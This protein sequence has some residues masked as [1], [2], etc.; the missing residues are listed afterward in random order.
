MSRV[1]VSCFSI[2]VDGY[3]AGP[4]QT[5]EEPLGKGGED[6]HQWMFGTR[7]F[8][9][10]SGRDTGTT[11]PDDDF[12]ARSMENMGAWILGRNM[13]AP[14][15]GPWPDDSWK[16]WWG[17]N[18]PYRVP[19]FVLTHHAHDPIEMEGGTTFYFVTDGI[20]SALEQARTVAKG[21]DIR[22]GGGVSTIRQYLQ[23]GLIDEMHLAIS[24]IVLGSGE[25]LLHGIDLLASG[26]AVT[27]HVTSPLA[28][29]VVMTKAR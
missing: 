20:H 7:T 19:V 10:M 3:G 25:H 1:T 6:L 9:Q 5:R 15:R 18:P 22:I 13:F 16:G 29:H 2:S 12:V 14:S 8:N 27:K 21:K 17:K 24:P 28:L 11:G 26:F 23:A 4:S